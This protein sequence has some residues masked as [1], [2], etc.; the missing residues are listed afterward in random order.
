MYR[1]EMQWKI[2]GQVKKEPLKIKIE[3]ITDLRLGQKRHDLFKRINK[4][5]DK[6]L[7]LCQNYCTYSKRIQHS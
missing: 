4:F 2:L 6:R 5:L 1:K 7:W 3:S